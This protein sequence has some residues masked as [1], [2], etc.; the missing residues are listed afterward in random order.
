MNNGKESGVKEKISDFHLFRSLTSKV[1]T[2]WIK[3]SN[4]KLRSTEK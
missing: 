3:T 4:V 2:V 1:E